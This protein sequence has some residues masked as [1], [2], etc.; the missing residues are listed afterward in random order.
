MDDLGMVSSRLGDD[1]PSRRDIPRGTRERGRRRE[2]TGRILDDELGHLVPPCDQHLAI[3]L[4]DLILASG[5]PVPVVHLENAH[6]S[7]ATRRQVVRTLRGVPAGVPYG[8]APRREDGHQL[9]EPVPEGLEHDVAL[10]IGGDL[11]GLA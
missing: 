11:D 6:L 7:A 4:H 1:P 3:T 2:R 5:N 9:V 8:P 10:A